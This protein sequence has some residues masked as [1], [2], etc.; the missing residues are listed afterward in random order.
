MS[1]EAIVTPA[2]DFKFCAF[3]TYSWRDEETCGNLSQDSQSTSRDLNM[4]SRVYKAEVTGLSIV[5]RPSVI[6]S[7]ASF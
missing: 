1:K 2:F 7:A 6:K 3:P 5:P 4:G